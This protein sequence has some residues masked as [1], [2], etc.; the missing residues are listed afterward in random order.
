MENSMVK[1]MKKMIIRILWASL[2]MAL[3]ACARQ[4]AT[5]TPVI[6]ETTSKKEIISPPSTKPVGDIKN[7]VCIQLWMPVCGEN[8][9]T[10]SN[11]CFAKC[12][13]VKFKQGS[14]TKEISD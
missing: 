4:K 5:N 14:C 9:K 8:G 6:A 10:Y 12:A 2:F 3:S 7:C 13:N 11:A 1:M